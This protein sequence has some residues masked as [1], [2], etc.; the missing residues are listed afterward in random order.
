[1]RDS[2]R[3]DIEMTGK[4]CRRSKRPPCGTEMWAKLEGTPFERLGLVKPPGHQV[5]K[6][7]G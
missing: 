5:T 4:A 1:M 3:G 7:H 2:F 6:S